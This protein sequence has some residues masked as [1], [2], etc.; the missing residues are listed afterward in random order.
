M[1]FDLNTFFSINT[2]IIGLCVAAVYLIFGFVRNFKQ[3]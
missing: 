1:I 3:F 2:L